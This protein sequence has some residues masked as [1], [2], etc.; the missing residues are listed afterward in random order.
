MAPVAHAVRAV[1]VVAPSDLADPIRRIARHGGHGGR[2]HAAGQ[3]PEEVPMATLDR[4]TC[5]AIAVVEFVVSQV[6]F[7]ANASWHPPFYNNTLRRRI[8]PA[9]PKPCRVCT[10]KCVGAQQR[11]APVW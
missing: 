7:E 4:I 2:R 11:S 5:P 10:I 6:E 8:S 9:G 3:Q 1:S